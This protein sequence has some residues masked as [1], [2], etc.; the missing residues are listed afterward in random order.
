MTYLAYEPGSERDKALDKEIM[1]MIDKEAVELVD[2][3]E[4]PFLGFYSRFF[5]VPKLGEG[6]WR[7][8]IDLSRLNKFMTVPHMQI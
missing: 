1:E 4:S 3:Q 2:L 7:T 8:R 6:N 5:V